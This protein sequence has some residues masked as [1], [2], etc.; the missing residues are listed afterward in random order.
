MGI[1]G[2]ISAV[3]REFLFP[4]G[5]AVC[6]MP[7][8]G[9]HECLLGVCTDCADRLVPES[10]ERCPHCGRP[11][12]SELDLCA[13]C[14]ERPAPAYDRARALFRYGGTARSLLV[15]YKFGAGRAAAFF[16]AD[17]IREE[18]RLVAGEAVAVPVPPRHGK[19][20]R[21]GWDQVELV[22]R[23]LERSG[24]QVSRCLRRLPSRSQKEL[25][26]GEGR[27]IWS[28]RSSASPLRRGR[29]PP[30]RRNHHGRDPGRLRE[31]AQGGR[32]RKGIRARVLLRLRGR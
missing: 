16:I 10:G 23:R 9:G 11:L 17:L 8:L 31:V 27:R 32:Q 24:T 6:G 1:P 19:L 14:R 4:A 21:V 30:R 20:K 22:A 13:E 5:C 18:L 29:G 15:A 28:E 26:R 12:V 25:D 7:L 2:L 3:A